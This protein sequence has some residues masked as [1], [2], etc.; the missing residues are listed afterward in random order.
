MRHFILM[1]CCILILSAFKGN[2]VLRYDNLATP[3]KASSILYI[4]NLTTKNITGITV[5]KSSGS[6]Y[7]STNLAPWDTYTYNMGNT[8]E[9]ISVTIHL[10]NATS[11]SLQVNQNDPYECPWLACFSFV[12]MSMP[13]ITFYMYSPRWMYVLEAQYCFC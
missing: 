5:T 3:K 10:S 9:N 1:S 6:Y 7:T 2:N 12:S 4:N 13:E 8:T 11:G